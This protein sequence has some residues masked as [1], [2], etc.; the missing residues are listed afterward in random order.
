MIIKKRYIDGCFSCNSRLAPKYNKKIKSFP[1]VCVKCKTINRTIVKNCPYCKSKKYEMWGRPVRNFFSAK[2][3]SCGI[4]YIKNPLSNEGQ[5][6]FYKYYLTN[7]HQKEKVKNKQ[8]SKMYRLELDFLIKNMI[9]FKKTKDILDVGCGGGYFLDLLKKEG[10]KTHGIEVGT[11]SYLVAKR[12]HKMYFGEFG[13]KLK[14]KKKFDLIIFRGVIEHVK[15]PT[16]YVL[17]AQKLLKRGGYIFITA[18]PNLD[19]A[20]AKIFK[21]RWSLHRP[22]SHLLHLSEEHVDKIFNKKSFLKVASKSFYL[23]TPYENLEKDLVL[24]LNEIRKQKRK[25]K[26]DKISPAFFE[27]MMTVLFKKNN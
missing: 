4:V 24:I 21:E 2:C 10:K 22:E 16:G 8:R 25:I 5:N 6:L 26:S 23:D 3:N 1:R 17:K 15:N 19:C 11:D 18:T 27:S 20:A 14:I 13:H 7:V 9:N 12:K